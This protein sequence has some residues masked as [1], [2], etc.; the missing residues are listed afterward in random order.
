MAVKLATWAH[1]LHE[2]VEVARGDNLMLSAGKFYHNGIETEP[3]DFIVSLTGRVVLDQVAT[4]FPLVFE[5]P[6]R[7]YYCPECVEEEVPYVTG[8]LIAGAV[9]CAGCGRTI[10]GEPT[11]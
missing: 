5:G 4:F 10:H 2:H 1:V 8:R 7:D 6:T 9:T 3:D 11:L